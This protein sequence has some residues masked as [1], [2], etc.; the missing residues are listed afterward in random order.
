M[1][2]GIYMWKFGEL[3]QY[4]VDCD[5]NA[6]LCLE[7]IYLRKRENLHKTLTIINK[8]IQ[9]S[10]KFYISKT[11]IERKHV[12]LLIDEQSNKYQNF[13]YC[14]VIKWMYKKRFR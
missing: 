12:F 1:S 9:L 3:I 2:V 14:N 7:L 10:D 6:T 4:E 13:E 11:N 8:N 5:Y